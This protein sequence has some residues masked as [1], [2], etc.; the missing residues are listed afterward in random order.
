ME[1]QTNKYNMVTTNF[2]DNIFQMNVNAKRGSKSI[3]I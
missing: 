3:N 2:E 1:A